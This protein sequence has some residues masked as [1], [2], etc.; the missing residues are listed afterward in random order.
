[1][2]VTPIDPY[3]DSRVQRKTAQLNGH[4]Y[5]Y[6]LALPAGGSFQHTIFLVRERRECQNPSL[7]RGV[8][9]RS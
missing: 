5:E 8:I 7:R 9:G 2:G 3:E 4:T 6:L 1:M